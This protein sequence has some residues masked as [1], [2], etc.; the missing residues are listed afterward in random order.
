MIRR[1][2]QGDEDNEEKEILELAR[3]LSR[4]LVGKEVKHAYGA[5]SSK[6]SRRIKR[7]ETT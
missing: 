4:P 5:G 3:R 7:M 2:L 1:T 6:E